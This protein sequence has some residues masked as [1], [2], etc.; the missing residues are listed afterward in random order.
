[1]DMATFLALAVA[2]MALGSGGA[3][4][5]DAVPPLSPIRLAIDQGA[6]SVLLQVNGLTGTACS[7]S[8][9][10]EVSGGG[11]RSTQRGTANLQ[12][13]TPVTL[14][15]LRLAS[16]GRRDWSATLTVVA[17]DGKRYEQTEASS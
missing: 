7:A 1:M 15:N 4:A 3:V 9:T 8:Y 14:V 17:C 5:G 2:V 12:P 11:N 13:N 10:L 16:P 6:D